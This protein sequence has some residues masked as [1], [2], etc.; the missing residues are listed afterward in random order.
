MS[1][2]EFKQRV[3]IAIKRAGGNQ[4]Q[5]AQALRVSRSAVN[6]WKN[7]GTGMKPENAILLARRANVRPEWL[8]LGEQPMEPPNVDPALLA[9]LVDVMS[10]LDQQRIGEVLEFGY[11]K[12]REAI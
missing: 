1:T 12:K 8:I 2:L 10:G 6:Q 3:K 5:I 11:F 4:S 7:A 9:K